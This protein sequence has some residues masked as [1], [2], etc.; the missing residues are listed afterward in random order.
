L[1]LTL[2]RTKLKP[3]DAI[4]YVLEGTN[5]GVKP[6]MILDEFWR[7]QRYFSQNCAL[8]SGTTFEI[9]GPDGK[10]VE[11]N[12]YALG[13]HGEF[14]FWANGRGTFRM[15]LKGGESTKAAP[16][17]I[18]PVR[19][20]PHFDYR[21][22]PIPARRDEWMQSLKADQKK[23]HDADSP[24]WAQVP[25]ERPVWAPAD[26]R[27]LQGYD[28]ILP[29]KYKIRVVYK[30]GNESAAAK[31]RASGREGIPGFPDETTAFI[32]YSPWLEFE[33]AP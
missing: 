5:V 17:I 26:A 11:C 28:P 33:V 22:G 19:D 3:H 27:I 32:Y 14:S 4:W 1:K 29:G 30:A 2:V 8:N 7:E 13:D 10:A 31:A 20:N 16:S 23:G 21:A 24:E 6:L 9:I 18:A 25:F 12:L 15:E